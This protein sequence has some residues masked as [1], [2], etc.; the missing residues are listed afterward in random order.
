M[1]VIFRSLIVILLLINI[2]GCGNG[3][4]NSKT[5]LNITKLEPKN[6]SILL[7]KELNISLEINSTKNINNIPII[8]YVVTLK[9]EDN[10]SAIDKQLEIG[11]TGIDITSGVNNYNIQFIT[12]TD[13]NESG[14]YYITAQ[15]DPLNTIEHIASKENL[16]LSENKIEVIKNSQPDI[17]LLKVDIDRNIR[18][19]EISSI[20]LNDGN[21]SDLNKTH[22]LNYGMFKTFS[23]DNLLAVND[24][25]LTIS[26]ML[27]IL[28]LVKDMNHTEIT[29]CIKLDGECIPLQFKISNDKNQTILIDKKEVNLT[30]NH[31]VNISFELF[32]DK[33]TL[34]II[35]KK[36]FK[37]KK[38]EA[39]NIDIQFKLENS[40]YGFE[41]EFIRT[42]A[43]QTNRLL[44]NY[45][46]TEYDPI[47]IASQYYSKPTVMGDE[48]NTTEQ[49]NNIIVLSTDEVSS[50]YTKN[51]S[52]Q[53]IKLDNS[54][55]QKDYS[56][57][58]S[59][60][61]KYT[62]SYE[63]WRNIFNQE[64]TDKY[65][66]YI[67]C[68]SYLTLNSK[69]FEFEFNK[70]ASDDKG[71]FGVNLSLYGGTTLDYHGIKAK[72]SGKT[73]FTI[74]K[75]KVNIFNI[76]SIAKIDPISFK[77]TG[78]STTLKI[79]NFNIYS[80]NN[81]LYKKTGL[82]NSGAT[83]LKKKIKENQDRINQRYSRQEQRS[84][85]HLSG[86]ISFGL[87]D[88]INKK[89]K[90]K[91]EYTQ[92]IVLGPIP[93]NFTAE[94]NPTIGIKP[95]IGLDGI[96][97]I[98]ANITPYISAN[99]ILSATAGIKDKAEVGV[100]GV[101][102]LI[103]DDFITQA[104]GKLDLVNKDEKTDALKGQVTETIKNKVF[105]PSGE[106]NAIVKVGFSVLGKDIEVEKSYPLADFEAPYAR[107]NTLLKK[108]VSGFKV[109]IP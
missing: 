61:D 60:L 66:K 52:N 78:Y 49:L 7:G 86:D 87:S 15:I 102:T 44:E 76:D 107:T 43:I 95:S 100:E 79:I 19:G 36:L 24:K 2:N 11:S 103:E 30:I 1:N 8:F 70:N 84:L 51:S 9:D 97:G 65:N 47:Y 20:I 77:S 96:T 104:S 88:I 13:I 83:D 31:S 4:G 25:N 74:L 93:V 101:L 81:D 73:S 68:L 55:Y 40:D 41:K 89:S 37:M 42:L 17:R 82:R 23:G 108:R 21:I 56:C 92:T 75:H 14:E 69:R 3:G 12:L 99:I 48:D 18:D 39:L 94:I 57:T 58:Y 53:K 59:D 98:K 5:L 34:N 50:D 16:Y 67:E 71:Y 28:P 109:D 33:D 38:G 64:V 62:L 72:T 26:G 54:L 105:G 10:R 35:T 22:F 85:I 6:S 63:D 80:S 32:I 29:A 106:L 90:I 27:S 46:D 91:L 45:I